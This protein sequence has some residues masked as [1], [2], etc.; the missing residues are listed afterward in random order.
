MAA[1]SVL[2]G[3]LTFCETVKICAGNRSLLGVAQMI[4]FD[5]WP[6]VATYLGYVVSPIYLIGTIAYMS[7]PFG[8]SQ[9]VNDSRCLQISRAVG[10]SH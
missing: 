4:D 5:N 1:R 10:I 3:R 6:R 7:T 8:S 2:Y 9:F